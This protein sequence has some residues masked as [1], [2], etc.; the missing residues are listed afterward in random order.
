MIVTVSPNTAT[1]PISNACQWGR[2]SLPM[3]SLLDEPGRLERFVALVGF[4][5]LSSRQSGCRER[6]FDQMNRSE[7]A[8]RAYSL[9]VK[10]A[11]EL[12]YGAQGR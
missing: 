9:S 3:L 5:S 1:K 12:R 6:L 8:E 11:G 7:L 2:S 4:C 10:C